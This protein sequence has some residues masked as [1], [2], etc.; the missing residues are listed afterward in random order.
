MP[1][2]KKPAAKAD[3]E[4]EAPPTINELVTIETVD[5]TFCDIKI[6]GR[7]DYE[8]MLSLQK[9]VARAAHSLN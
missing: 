6:V 1:A 2:A 7:F 3:P 9:I 5:D 4:P 8:Q